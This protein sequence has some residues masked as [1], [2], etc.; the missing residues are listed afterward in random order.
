MSNRQQEHGIVVG[1][2]GS[3]PS[4]KALEWALAQ[5]A[6]TG[7][8]VL[9]VLV[10]HIPA[11]YGTAA[12]VLPA[13]AFADQARWELEKTV[14]EIAAEWPQVHVVRRVVEGHPAKML[15]KVAEHADLL[16]VGSRGHGGF[17]GA[18]IGSVSQYCVTHARCP[19]VIVRPGE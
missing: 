19:V 14:D 5:G 13:A 12:M 8:S 15:L 16:V 17:V 6:A 3:E 9:A 11:N 7:S 2:D 10:W 1:V 4:K 18:M